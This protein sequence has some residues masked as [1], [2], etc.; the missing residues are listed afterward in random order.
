MTRSRF[1]IG[2]DITTPEKG[3]LSMFAFDIRVSK[4]EWSTVLV[5]HRIYC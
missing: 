3:I 2:T 1:H 4:R 5:H